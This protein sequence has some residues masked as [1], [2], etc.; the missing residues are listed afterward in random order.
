MY[1]I[2]TYKIKKFKALLSKAEFHFAF[3]TAIHGGLVIN[4]KVISNLVALLE[5]MMP[6]IEINMENNDRAC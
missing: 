4:P 1:I 2:S 5:L 6:T 3:Y